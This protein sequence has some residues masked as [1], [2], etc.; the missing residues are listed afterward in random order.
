MPRCYPSRVRRARAAHP[1]RRVTRR[2]AQTLAGSLGVALLC[3]CSGG[4]GV[5]ELNWVFV[6]RNG[7]G[8]YPGDQ[9]GSNRRDNSCGLHGR[10]GDGATVD[11]DLEVELEI[12]D[13][14]CAAG[15]E[16]AECLVGGPRRF[17]C[18]TAR[19]SDPDVPSADHP[20]R[21]TVHAVVLPS[22]AL[23]CSDAPST[24]IDVPGPRERT[25]EEG[26]PTDLQVYQIK[27]DIDDREGASRADAQLDLEAC[28]CA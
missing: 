27:L 14:S 15:C 17:S 3:G 12:C 6:D 22:D 7:E 11:Y 4:A 21:F 5:V 19:G 2:G 8:I 23:E 1:V 20:Y 28:G 9:L 18:E 10:L 26:L 16:S 24:C 25:V 13:P